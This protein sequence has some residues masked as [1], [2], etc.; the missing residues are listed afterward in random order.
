VTETTKP[1][2][3]KKPGP[4]CPNCGGKTYLTRTTETMSRG[5]L[6]F[7]VKFKHYVCEKGCKRFAS[8]EMHRDNNRAISTAWALKRK[9]ASSKGNA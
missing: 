3:P 2:K 4:E 6:S 1:E 5:H 7:P 9:Q 8:P